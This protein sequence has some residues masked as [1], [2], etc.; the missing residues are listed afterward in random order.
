MDR[1]QPPLLAA[2][3]PRSM[4]IPAGE[5]VRPRAGF[6]PRAPSLYHP[7]F[8]LVPCSLL[9]LPA[10]PAHPVGRHLLE[11]FHLPRCE[12]PS[13]TLT[14]GRNW[15]SIPQARPWKWRAD[16]VPRRRLALCP[17]AWLRPLGLTSLFLICWFFQLYCL[18]SYWGMGGGRGASFLSSCNCLDSSVGKV[19]FLHTKAPVSCQRPECSL[20]PKL[21]DSELFCPA[22]PPTPSP[23]ST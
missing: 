23:T 7:S 8:P 19:I 5:L 16:V 14:R 6:H 17:P 2:A 11:P 22:A 15:A 12:E 3:W 9:Y 21:L 18:P 10:T 13:L 4:A 1:D 20:S